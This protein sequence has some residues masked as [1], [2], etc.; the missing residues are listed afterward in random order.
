LNRGLYGLYAGGNQTEIMK[1]G[2]EEEADSPLPMFDFL[3]FAA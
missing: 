1:L 3:N 2:L